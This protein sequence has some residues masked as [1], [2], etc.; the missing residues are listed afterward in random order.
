MRAVVEERE[1][2]AYEMHD[3][4]AQSVAGIGFQLEAIRVGVPEDLTKVHQQ[5]DL[6]SELTRHSHAEARHSVDM[7]RPQELES[8][9]LLNA[10]TSCA[11]RLVAGGSVR[12]IP[13]ST[14]DV[15][16]PLFADG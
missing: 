16:A 14:G 10:L 9:G 13:T 11:H 7:L 6:A 3:T 4:L 12:I 15:R 1:S 5:L 8:E 2:L